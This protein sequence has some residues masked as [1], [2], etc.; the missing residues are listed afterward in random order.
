M[1]GKKGPGHLVVNINI[2]LLYSYCTVVYA[3][4]LK[5]TQKNIRLCCY[6]F[7]IGGISI[8]R[9]GF[10]PLGYAYDAVGDS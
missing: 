4:M 1:D 7:I 9:A 6:N 2:S 8:W 3:E 5:E 10:A